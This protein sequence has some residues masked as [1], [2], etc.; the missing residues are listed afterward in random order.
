MIR[1]GTYSQQQQLPLQ[2]STARLATGEIHRQCIGLL[3]AAA[4]DNTNTVYN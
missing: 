3:R 4:A 1:H 2:R